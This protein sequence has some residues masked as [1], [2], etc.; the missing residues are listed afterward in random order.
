MIAE[1][2]HSRKT[3]MNCRYHDIGP[4]YF[5][6]LLGS[7]EYPT[8]ILSCDRD[9]VHDE[10]QSNPNM[11]R[12][13]VVYRKDDCR[14]VASF[15]S[16]RFTHGHEKE[17]PIYRWL[18]DNTDVNMPGL[19]DY[20]YDP[21]RDNCWML[22]DNWINFKDMEYYYLCRYIFA[23]DNT[24]P[25][26]TEPYEP[27]EA[28]TIPLADLHGKTLRKNWERVDHGPI[29]VY[30]PPLSFDVDL[31]NIERTF[32]EER[33]LVDTSTR[34][35][36]VHIVDFMG[37]LSPTKLYERIRKHIAITHGSMNFQEVGFRIDPDFKPLWCLFDW[38]SARIAPIYFDLAQVHYS[39]GKAIGEN[40]LSWY[41]NEV[42]CLSG[43]RLDPGEV[44][45]AIDIAYLLLGLER[46]AWAAI[47]AGGERLDALLKRLELLQ[48]KTDMN[49]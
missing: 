12:W 9:G 43:I 31:P 4:E 17:I 24:W 16:K 15:V 7:E 10:H 5:A 39:M 49:A 40:Q 25:P 32:A 36:L 28:Y 30:E 46:L 27:D 42:C 29:P 11:A 37:K 2:S 48:S 26:A 18:Q 13:R 44:R 6:S 35:K 8:E 20:C 23:P 34:G 21:K 19:V 47:S 14:Y 3:N 38:E 22:T 33:V 45:E 41:I 1:K